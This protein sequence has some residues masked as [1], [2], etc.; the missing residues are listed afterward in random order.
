MPKGALKKSVL[1]PGILTPACFSKATDS[2]RRNE[3]K[4]A[5]KHLE[6][7]SFVC[8]VFSG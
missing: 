1:T 8:E 7:L 3:S 2:P 5:L 6:T 4:Q